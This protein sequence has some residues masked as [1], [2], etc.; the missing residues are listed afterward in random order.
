MLDDTR[1]DIT[2]LKKGTGQDIAWML[3]HLMENKLYMADICTGIISPDTKEELQRILPT[4]TITENEWK[5]IATI[6]RKLG[7]YGR[8]VTALHGKLT[9]KLLSGNSG[10]KTGLT[11]CA[12][13][14][15]RS[16]LAAL[17]WNNSNHSNYCQTANTKIRD[18]W[19]T[20]PI[21]HNGKSTVD[22]HSMIRWHRV[23]PTLET[24][25]TLLT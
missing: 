17:G 11:R 22:I 2:L 5:P 19:T 14:P 6:L 23:K 12:I 20:D 4:V 16:I 7:K 3:F 13:G 15:Q 18:L 21:E 24:P 25:R 1:D 10:A 8:D 9:N